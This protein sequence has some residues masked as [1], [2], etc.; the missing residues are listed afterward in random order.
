MNTP[1]CSRDSRLQTHSYTEGRQQ[2]RRHGCA[3]IRLNCENCDGLTLW[4][5]AQSW[6]VLTYLRA[7]GTSDF[8]F[9]LCIVHW[10][11]TQPLEQYLHF[12]SFVRQKSSYQ[13]VKFK[14]GFGVVVWF[15]SRW[16]GGGESYSFLSN[17]GN[18][19]FLYRG[20]MPFPYWRI[21]RERCW[22]GILR[23]SP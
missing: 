4:R 20:R 15:F 7:A 17:I 9:F 23:G 6:R 1:L 12:F 11:F 13:K 14:W 3:W 16:R 21:V 10:A 8:D 5:R 22:Q 18:M 2:H 19:T